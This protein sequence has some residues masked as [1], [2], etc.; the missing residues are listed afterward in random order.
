MWNPPAAGNP[1]PPEDERDAG[2]LVVGIA[3]QDGAVLEDLLS[4]VGGEHEQGVVGQVELVQG[5]EQRAEPMLVDV[6]H[7]GV[8][9][10]RQEL[11]IPLR[12]PFLR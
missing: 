3:V 4:V 9:V 2:G 12:G 11:E 10:G 7:A 1:W 6:A 5:C 8:V